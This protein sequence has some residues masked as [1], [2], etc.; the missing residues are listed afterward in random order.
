M[1]D[2]LRPD[3]AGVVRVS[4]AEALA[5]AARM[6]SL[7]GRDFTLPTMHQLRTALDLESVATSGPFGAKRGDSTEEW[8]LD[9]PP[10]AGRT[11]RKPLR[12]VEN[13]PL[14]W[15]I[16]TLSGQP[17]AVND[18]IPLTPRASVV[19]TLPPLPHVPG[20]QPEFTTQ[21]ASQAVLLGGTATFAAEAMA[22]Y[23]PT[24]QW[25]FN[26]EAITGATARNLVLANV[27]PTATGTYWVMATNTVI[28]SGDSGSETFTYSA[29]SEL[30]VLQVTQPG[31][32]GEG[33]RITQ[34][35]V[36]RTVADGANVSFS[37]RFTGTQPMAISLRWTFNASGGPTTPPTSIPVLT[38]EGDTATIQLSNVDTSHAGDYALHFTNA[39]GSVRSDAATL[40]VI[41]G[42]RG[43]S[44]SAH[45]SSTSVARGA[46]ATFAVTA[47][48]VPAPTFQW[49]LDGAPIAGATASSFSIANVQSAHTG[50]YTV[51]VKNDL[52]EV[53]SNAATLTI[54]PGGST[55]TGSGGGG[56]PHL[57]FLLAALLLLIVPRTARRG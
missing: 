33:P 56:A 38:S 12:L 30:A 2:A 5:L 26:G 19:Q 32:S 37:V 14:H 10:S 41:V 9:A 8:T 23:A 35:P 13:A 45:P 21:P 15:Q 46:N 34:Q 55:A 49:N 25:F 50:S 1:P 51:T 29:N 18:P 36:S 39:Y 7:A 48:G 20:L 52:G 3:S 27:Q 40:R 47:S 11:E 42:G 43:P 44:I 28:A 57:G 24:Y 4:R 53:A 17:L 31:E 54:N 6:S 16:D 22:S